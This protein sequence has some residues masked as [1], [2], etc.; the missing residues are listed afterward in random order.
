MSDAGFNACIVI[1]I[2]N[3]KDA[4]GGTVERLAVHGLPIFVVDDGSDEPTQAVLAKLA[5]QH[6][7]QM[8]LLRLPVNGGKGA[9]VMAGL[10]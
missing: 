9:A 5:C 7:E 6:R 2:Y 3:H 10:R 8:T 4:I 1:P